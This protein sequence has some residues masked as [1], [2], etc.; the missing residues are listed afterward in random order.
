M[1]VHHHRLAE[2][3][4][5][6]VVLLALVS[7]PGAAS[8]PHDFDWSYVLELEGGVTLGLYKVMDTNPYVF[9]SPGGRI[10]RVI[11]SGRAPWARF[12]A[13]NPGV[14]VVAGVYPEDGASLVLDETTRF[15]FA[16]SD[17]E[18]GTSSEI[19]SSDIIMRRLITSHPPEMR[20]FDPEM[21][22]LV[23]SGDATQFDRSDAGGF[24]L[25]I[26]FD[27]LP[28]GSTYGYEVPDQVYLLKGGE[29]IAE[30]R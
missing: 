27:E 4:I 5:L 16:Y 10:D 11:R 14:Y 23:L 29:R 15:V 9:R 3:L 28:G 17:E 1:S 30:A 26:R 18:D 2:R 7:G 8:F 22:P 13:E 6:T 12:I 19:E 24:K 21:H 20:L 25:Y